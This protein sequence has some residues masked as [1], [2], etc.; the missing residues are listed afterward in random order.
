MLMFRFYNII[1][2]VSVFLFSFGGSGLNGDN[3][4]KSGSR[5]VFWSSRSAN[6]KT[7]GAGRP[8]YV[9]VAKGSSSKMDLWAIGIK[10]KTSF[11]LTKD[12]GAKSAVQ[13]APS[14]KRVVYVSN[15]KVY[16]VPLLSKGG[17]GKKRVELGTLPKGL[18]G[19]FAHDIEHFIKLGPFGKYVAFPNE[20]GVN[21]VE[22][23][24]GKSRLVKA[25]GCGTNRSTA[26][27]D[28]DD[29]NEDEDENDDDEAKLMRPVHPVFWASNRQAFLYPAIIGKGGRGGVQ[30]GVYDVV[31]KRQTH[32]L[33]LNIRTR[34]IVSRGI[35]SVDRLEGVWNDDG[36][37]VAVSLRLRLRK[38]VVGEKGGAV[39]GDQI[40]VFHRVISLAEKKQVEPPS[41]ISVVRWKGWQ[42]RSGTLLFTGRYKKKLKF[43][44]WI[45]PLQKGKGRVTGVGSI[46]KGYGLIS[47]NPYLRTALLAV[48]GRKGCRKTRLMTLKKGRKRS[49]IRWAVW[50]EMLANDPSGQWGI[51][52]GAARC[53]H[54]RPVLYLMRVDGSKLARELP[55]RFRP[56][57]TL[58]ASR[59][60]VCP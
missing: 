48:P 51:F 47:Y 20:K 17:R 10:R 24:T 38:K 45:D 13:C 59:V 4:E 35:D 22:L 36:S 49:L 12:G 34:E 52:R 58:P 27:A 31:Q 2:F 39:A 54:K 11:R 26:R 7:A 5:W 46:G 25:Q 29:E 43:Y 40:R 37:K 8:D 55:A 41:E 50:S 44:A 32:C 6:A 42:Y 56:L 15:G 57:R 53:H 9:I 30:L 16:S 60:A 23:D 33:N 19:A 21:V 14:G 3:G 18:W 1:V 28:G